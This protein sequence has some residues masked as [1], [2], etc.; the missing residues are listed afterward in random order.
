[1]KWIDLSSQKSGQY[2]HLNLQVHSTFLLFL[3]TILWVN[4][5]GAQTPDAKGPVKGLCMLLTIE[6]KVEVSRTGSTEWALAQTNQVLQIGDRVRTSARSR[7]GFK[8]R[9]ATKK[10]ASISMCGRLIRRR[11]RHCP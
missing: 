3:F 4:L 9:R 10:T 7:N 8:G 11:A 1:M 6:G 2:F 5:A